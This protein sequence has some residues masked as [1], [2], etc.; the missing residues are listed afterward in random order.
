VVSDS[1]PSCLQTRMQNRHL[2][3]SA[4]VGD[5]RDSLGGEEIAAVRAASL[6]GGVF[7]IS[8]F[9]VFGARLLVLLARCRLSLA[10]LLLL[11]LVRLSSGVPAWVPLVPRLT[12]RKLPDI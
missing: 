2:P 12:S 10:S 5:S 3:G 11:V 8:V 1:V 7:H 9:A 4:D 6:A